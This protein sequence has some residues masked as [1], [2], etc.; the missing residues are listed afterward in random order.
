M[1]FIIETRRMIFSVLLASIVL[2]AGDF[3]HA[4]ADVIVDNGDPGTSYTGTWSVSGGADPWDPDD[5]SANSVWSRD[6]STYTWAFT[7]MVS[8]AYELSM[9]W[10]QYASRSSNIP[11]LIEFSGGTD[12]VTVNQ[13]V[14][15]GRWNL[16][17]LYNFVA[18]VSYDIRITSQ[19]GPTS[20]CADAVRFVPVSTSNY[21]I[22]HNRHGGV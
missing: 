3:M 17:G 5:P 9:W 18:G 22:Y 7:P 20:T 16:L 1:T 13:Q 19:P 4:F 14:N 10:A 2:I 15:G 12:T 6:G 11:V 8:G 21:T